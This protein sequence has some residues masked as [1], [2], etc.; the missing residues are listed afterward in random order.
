MLFRKYHIQ[1]MQKLQSLSGQAFG[2][3]GIRYLCNLLLVGLL[4]ATTGTTSN[5]AGEKKI[6]LH[7]ALDAGG[8]GYVDCQGTPDTTKGGKILLRDLRDLEHELNSDRNEED[9]LTNSLQEELC[10]DGYVT[11]SYDQPGSRFIDPGACV[12]TALANFF[13][14]QCGVC[15]KPREY[16]RLV[17]LQRGG[18][19][20]FTDSLS[21]QPIVDILNSRDERTA[22]HVNLLKRE[23][24][25]ENDVWSSAYTVWRDWRSEWREDY[26]LERGGPFG[27]IIDLIIG[28]EVPEWKEYMQ[29]NGFSLLHKWTKATRHHAQNGS[30]MSNPNPVLVSIND[31]SGESGHMTTV[32]GVNFNSRE[33]VH[34]TWGRQYTTPWKVF[35]YLWEKSEFAAIYLDTEKTET[36]KNMKLRQELLAEMALTEEEKCFANPDCIPK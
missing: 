27:I 11:V 26:R 21:F 30:W 10:D 8:F 32:I 20:V 7:S 19:G 36:R 33:V 29:K 24:Y 3:L 6:D 5:A 23:S 28:E 12:P 17:D 16:E 34:N 18:G 13:C 15:Q 22:K 14:I 2:E 4:C 25:C 9:Y 1:S 35:R 31:D